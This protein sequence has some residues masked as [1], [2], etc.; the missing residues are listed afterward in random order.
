MEN[1]N[2]IKDKYIFA[3]IPSMLLVGD[4][5]EDTRNR[6]IALFL[7]ELTKYNVLIKD[8]VNYNLKEVDR[9]IALNVAHYIIENDELLN[10]IV[11]KL[12][13][14]IS[15]LSKLTKIKSEYI[16][17]WRDY[18]LAYYLILSNPNYRGIQDYLRIVL[19]E[20]NNGGYVKNNKQ[21]IYKGLVIKSSK[22]S[23]YIVTSKGEFL[24]IKTNDK[25]NPG[26][27]CEGSL[28]KT[29]KNYRIH[30]SILLLILIVIVSG[31]IIEYRR[32]QSIVVIE[33]TSVIKIHINKY[34][35]V[36]YAYSPTEKG[37]ELINDVNMLNKDV[38][39][40]IADTFEYAINNNMLDLSKKTLIT[41]N[42]QAIKYGLFDKTNK[43]ITEN[44]IPIV[45][46]N[47]G[48]QQKL[49][50]YLSEDEN[51]TEK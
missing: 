28:K 51:K 1:I 14:P 48:N 30:I 43:I 44:K 7:K 13:L 16:E 23:A 38:D 34:N 45:I 9:N 3:S 37:K 31:I 26:D 17:K 11:N 42:G 21:Q 39:E 8:L 36:I 40:A 27:V 2:F 20:D 29:L 41:I 33:T 35:K 46:N 18:I 25:I 50:K 6:Q 5:A 32:A 22:K 19:R 12:D 49:P 15:R 47:A 4:S 24:R 10:I